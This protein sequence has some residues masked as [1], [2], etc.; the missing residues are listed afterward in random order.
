MNLYRQSQNHIP[1]PTLQR[2]LGPVALKP[3][4]ITKTMTKMFA[5]NTLIDGQQKKCNIAEILKGDK[6]NQWTGDIGKGEQEC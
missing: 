5:V 1:I 4:V 3:V 6:Q 2:V